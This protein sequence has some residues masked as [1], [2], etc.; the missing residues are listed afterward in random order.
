[1]AIVLSHGSSASERG[2]KAGVSFSIFR[3]FFISWGLLVISGVFFVI[4]RFVLVFEM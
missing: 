4:F 3:F 2:E 1:M